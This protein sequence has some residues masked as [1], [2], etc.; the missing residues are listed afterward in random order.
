MSS[1]F[2]DRTGASTATERTGTE[3]TGTD[4]TG[5]PRRSAASSVLVDDL[6]SEHTLDPWARKYAHQFWKLVFVSDAPTGG[7]IGSWLRVDLP[8]NSAKSVMW[9][10]GV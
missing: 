8:R 10:R 1:R 6:P 3:R 2:T 7:W 5:A 4:R 9:G